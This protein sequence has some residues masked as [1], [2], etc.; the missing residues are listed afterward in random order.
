MKIKTI[1]MSPGQGRENRYSLHTLG[2]IAGV[3]GLILVV[4]LG[5]TAWGI[6]AGWPMEVV[7]VALCLGAAA[8]GMAL[9]VRVGRRSAGEA[10]VFF[11][12]E[13]DRLFVLDARRLVDHGHDVF[14]YAAA[15]AR[16]QRCLREIAVQFYLPSGAQEILKVE[17]LKENR[18]HCALVCLVR[19]GED[20]AVRQTFLLPEGLEHREELLRQLERRKGWENTVEV[21]ENR[22]PFRILASALVCAGFGAVC[23]FSHPAVGQLPETL[24]FPCLGL[25][26]LAL[27]CAVWFGV[28]QS[29]GE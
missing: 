12:V 19:Q 24:Y 2:G 15:T 16:V 22:N 21:V 5:G 28:K 29:R 20:G 4:C 14:R 7:S 17:N 27:C 26:F 8:L 10:L 9:A 6:L 1:W 11:L 18:G 25:A 3:V 13:G 23:V